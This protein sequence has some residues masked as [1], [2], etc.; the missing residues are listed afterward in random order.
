MKRYA[1][2]GFASLT[3]SAGLLLLT[4]TSVFAACFGSNEGAGSF[5][6]GSNRIR[7]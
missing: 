2:S 1:R 5:F 3:A 4:A 7:G 6:I